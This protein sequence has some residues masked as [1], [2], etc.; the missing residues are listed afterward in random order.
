MAEADGQEKTEAP[1]GRKLD[2]ARNKGQIPRSKEM[3]T[4]VVLL[5]SLVGLFVISR[6]LGE[7]LQAIFIRNFTLNRQ[8]IFD[9][10][11]MIQFLVADIQSLAFPLLSLFF[12]VVV[13]AIIGNLLL[14]GANFSGEAMLPKLSKLSPIAG[15]KR[16]FGVQSLVELIKSIAK[17]AF[18]GLLSWSWVMGQLPHILEL[19]QRQLPFAIFDALELCWWAA[20]MIC[21][22]LLPIVAIDIPFQIWNHTRQLRMTKQEIKDE[23][24]NSEGKPE[25]KGRIRR[26]QYEMANRRMMAEVPK[27]DV[28]VTNPTHYAVALKYDRLNGKAPVVIAKG[29]DEIAMKI[30]EIATAYNISIVASPTLARSIYYTTKLD[31]EIPEG[32]FVAVAQVLAYVYQLQAF[33]QGRGQAPKKLADDLPIPSQF[34]Y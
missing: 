27:A 33:R 21:C 2:E 3:G 34:R 32:L 14:G 22:A 7:A 17:V 25:V 6:P 11:T 10:W 8:D 13:A 24:K 31:G 4:A 5:T 16:M 1:T 30:R 26:L 29:G 18:I 15:L 28:V 9:P 12:I 20:L 23:H 19:G